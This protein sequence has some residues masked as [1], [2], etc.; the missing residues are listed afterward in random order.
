MARTLT[1]ENKEKLG[2]ALELRRAGMT[3]QEI[4]DTLKVPQ[5][6]ICRWLESMNNHV[7][8]K[9]DKGTP[10]IHNLKATL[11]TS[12]TLYQANYED[13]ADKIPPE[14]VD[15]II[16]DPPY[17]VA[18]NDISR[19]GRTDFKRN[20]GEWDKSQEELYAQKVNIWAGLMAKHLKVGGSLYLFMDTR[21]HY[22]WS[23]AFESNGLTHC[24]TL[25]WHRTNPAPQIRQVRWCHSYDA[26]LYY[27]KGPAKT[28]KWQGQNEMHDVLQGGIA[29]G[30]ERLW[31]PTQK[32]RWLLMR[33]V[34]VSSIPGDTLLDP[35]AGSGSTAFSCIQK[36]RKV[37]L[38]EP[39]PQYA[40]L[41]QGTAKDEFSR[42]VKVN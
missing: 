9:M 17:Q 22:L 20:Y 21:K 25:I 29:S 19:P 32:P 12:I 27:A 13:V 23:S 38:V 16:T 5:P 15:L 30:N 39:A 41:I 3:Q 2:E 11:S 37:I 31:H 8:T 7:S 34:L 10:N 36:I 33:L 35:F 26:I 40:G 42:L 4:A 28:F 14:S 18:N 24:N 1:P 6:T